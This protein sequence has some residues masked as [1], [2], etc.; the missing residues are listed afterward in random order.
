MAEQKTI[1]LPRRNE[2]YTATVVRIE[3][4]FGVTWCALCNRMVIGGD[5]FYV[6]DDRQFCSEKC[7]IDYIGD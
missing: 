7:V 6:F 3:D 2:D 5:N 4:P 1:H